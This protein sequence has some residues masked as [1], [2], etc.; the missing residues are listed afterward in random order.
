M[1]LAL[2]IYCSAT[3]RFGPRSI[4]G[5]TYSDVAVRA[6]LRHPSGSDSTGTFRAAPAPPARAKE[7]MAHRLQITAGPDLYKYLVPAR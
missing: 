6:S 5:A 2:L 3:D 7:R 4:E 1:M